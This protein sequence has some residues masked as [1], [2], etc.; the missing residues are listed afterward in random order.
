MRGQEEL[1]SKTVAKTAA[2]GLRC[3]NLMKQRLSVVGASRRGRKQARQMSMT[4]VL[5]TV[6]SYWR[7]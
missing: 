6:E 7:L 4:L 3:K 1:L 5:K 2:G